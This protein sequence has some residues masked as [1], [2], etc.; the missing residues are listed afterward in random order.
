MTGVHARDARG[1]LHARDTQADPHGHDMRGDFHGHDT[2]GTDRSC[3]GLHSP[4]FLPGDETVAA[5]AESLLAA[6]LAA[7]RLIGVTGR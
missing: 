7:A 6:Y 4:G 1:D 2:R 3:R 5:V